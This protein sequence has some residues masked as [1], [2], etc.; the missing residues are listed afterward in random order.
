MALNFNLLRSF[1]L[2]AREGSISGAARAGY[3]SQPA[4]SKAMRELEKQLGLP[5][6]E[7]SAR[8]VVLTEAGQLLFAHARALFALETQ[9]EAALS[10]L[11]DVEGGTLRIGATT[12]LANYVLPALLGEFRQLHPRVTLQLERANSRAIEA[13]LANYALDI[14]F[15]EGLPSDE[16]LQARAWREDEIVLICAPNHAL[17]TRELVWPNDLQNEN[18]LVRESGSGTRDW[19]ERAL[20]PYDLP[21]SNA[22]EINSAEAIVAAVAADLGI[23]FVSRAAA[24]DGLKLGKVRVVRV[25]EVEIRRPFY[26]LELRDRPRSPATRAFEAFMDS[27]E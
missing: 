4:L 8:G 21:P 10:S 24:G 13:Q 23:A 16:R 7:R 22:W 19:I 20:A 12:T 3:A 2:V 9:T 5:L 11:R 18:W 25:A 14:A 15:I 17:A 1:E 26:R 27:A 6:F